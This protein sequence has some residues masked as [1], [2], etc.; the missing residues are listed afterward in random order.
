MAWASA[1]L[2]ASSARLERASACVE[3]SDALAEWVRAASAACSAS[4]VSRS[5]AATASAERA[6]PSPPAGAAPVERSCA[7]SW[8][9]S[10]SR[11]RAS[12]ARCRSSVTART[13]S[14]SFACVSARSPASTRCSSMRS[15]ASDSSFPRT[16]SSS[17][18]RRSG[19]LSSALVRS[20][21]RSAE[22]DASSVASASTRARVS[23]SAVLSSAPRSAAPTARSS[24]WILARRE[25]AADLLELV[26]GA[27]ISHP[28]QLAGECLHALAKLGQRRARLHGGALTRL[29]EGCLQ[30]LDARAGLAQLG[31]H[32]APV[33]PGLPLGGERG[34]ERLDLLARGAE[35]RDGGASLLELR[36]QTLLCLRCPG[37]LALEPL[38]DGA[39]LLDDRMCP[40]ALRL[41]VR[42]H[43]LERAARLGKL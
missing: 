26:G 16:A 4:A 37:E 19:P 28:G 9:R 21:S 13:S 8:R 15:P 5:T 18:R 17:A 43:L 38:R 40:V 24:S 20:S 29:R 22:T 27:E 35:L 34:L 3:A 25:L 10:P 41:G 23:S 6:A 14:F 42:A 33:I 32:P 12:S 2:A 39:R 30:L 31:L 7:S 36:A 1:A 11:V